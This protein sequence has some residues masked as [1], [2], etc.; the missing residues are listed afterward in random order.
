M[1]KTCVQ[2][3]W[4]NKSPH[5][6]S[7]LDFSSI[8]PAQDIQSSWIRCQKLRIHYP[9]QPQWYDVH[10]YVHEWYQNCEAAPSQCWTQVHLKSLKECFITCSLLSWFIGLTFSSGIIPHTSYESFLFFFIS[11]GMLVVSFLFFFTFS[12]SSFSFFSQGL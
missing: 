3:H 8:F 4:C 6:I 11:I 9:V 7:L 5:L 2:K 10:D 12:P 1:H